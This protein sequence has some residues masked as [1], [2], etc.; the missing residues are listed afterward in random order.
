M[1]LSNIHNE[2]N[3]KGSRLLMCFE[4]EKRKQSKKNAQLKHNNNSWMIA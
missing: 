2:W 4:G 3:E 1:T